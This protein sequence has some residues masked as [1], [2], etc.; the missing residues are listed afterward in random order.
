VTAIAGMIPPLSYFS[1]RNCCTSH[2]PS[3][4]GIAKSET[5]ASTRTVMT[6][7]SAARPVRALSTVARDCCRAALSTS[8]VSS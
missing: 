8:S 6:I 4:P 3:S 7:V 5:I 2:R 1:R